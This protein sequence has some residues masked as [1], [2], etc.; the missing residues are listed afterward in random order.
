MKAGPISHLYE[1]AQLIL[2]ATNAGRMF[3]AGCFLPLPFSAKIPRKYWGDMRQVVA[4][5]W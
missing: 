1:G 5:G 4:I 3:W 2:G